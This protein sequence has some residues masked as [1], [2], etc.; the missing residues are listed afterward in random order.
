MLPMGPVELLALLLAMTLSAGH[1]NAKCS[2]WIY[3]G[4]VVSDDVIHN[5]ADRAVPLQPLEQALITE[6]AQLPV[7][8]LARSCLHIPHQLLLHNSIA[9]VRAQM[10]DTS[11]N[12]V[13]RTSLTR[14]SWTWSCTE[15]EMTGIPN[16]GRPLLV[17]HR[18]QA[19]RF[20]VGISYAV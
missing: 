16:L 8:Q 15:L 19:G 7:A 10:P 5:G 18:R 12:R 17:Q 13:E 2:T 9:F 11:V 4:F 14:C 20:L 3:R 1:M 6:P